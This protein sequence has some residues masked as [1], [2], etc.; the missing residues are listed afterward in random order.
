[1]IERTTKFSVLL[2][3]GVKLVEIDST[4]K[5]M[6][7]AN[8]AVAENPNLTVGDYLDGKIGEVLNQA[9]C[10]GVL[11]EASNECSPNVRKGLIKWIKD[12]MK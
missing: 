3:R 7:M 6:S 4:C 2:S 9:Q 5:E 1:M 10:T 12:P 8:Q 11:I